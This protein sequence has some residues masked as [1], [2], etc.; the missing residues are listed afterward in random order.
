MC[1]KRVLVV[2]DQFLVGYEL[3]EVLEQFGFECVG[4]F[5]RIPPALAAAGTEQLDVAILDILVDNETVY[6]VA[7]VLDERRIPFAFASGLP[8]ELDET[9]WADRPRLNKPYTADD[10]R[11]LIELLTAGAA[12][13]GAGLIR[14]AV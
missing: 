13:G 6:P 11:R 5:S 12:H 14:D 9:K 4:P 3:R 1:A 7:S 2:E 8:G 10:L